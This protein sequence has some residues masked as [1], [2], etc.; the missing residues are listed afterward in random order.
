MPKAQDLLLKIGSNDGF[1]CWFN[2]K[3]VGSWQG[4]RSYSADQDTVAVRGKQGTNRILLKIT[5]LGANWALGVHL[6]NKSGQPI[7]IRQVR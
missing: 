2:G 7:P 5:Q 6:T 4:S 3:V 1:K